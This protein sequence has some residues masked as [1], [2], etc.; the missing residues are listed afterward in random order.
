MTRDASLMSRSF[1]VLVAV[2]M[3]G[4]MIHYSILPGCLTQSFFSVL[5]FSLMET[6]V[7]V[8]TAFH[9][10]SAKF[11]SNIIHLLA[12]KNVIIAAVAFAIAITLTNTGVAF[13]S[14]SGTRLIKSLEPVLVTCVQFLVHARHP[15]TKGS[16]EPA[17]MFLLIAAIVVM[18][19]V[20]PVRMTV[21]AS[22]AAFLSTLGI[23]LRNVFIKK[24]LESGS[25]PSAMSDIQAAVNALACTLF[26]LVVC[27]RVLFANAGIHAD[28]LDLISRLPVIALACVTFAAFQIAA[29]LVL[30]RVS[31]ARQS[32]IKSVHSS[33]VT[34][35]T[36]LVQRPHAGLRLEEIAPTTVW[37][38]AVLAMAADARVDRASGHQP[39]SGALG[40]SSKSSVLVAHNRQLRAWQFLLGVCW[41]VLLCPTAMRALGVYSNN[42][43]IRDEPQSPATL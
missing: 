18:L 20:S 5:V 24:E 23:V 32:A 36:L 12:E 3:A 29:V 9:S 27:A 10:R 1:A 41:A 16:Q 33:V 4:S 14:V 37:C 34:L 31:A 21:Y 38:V 30:G 39:E 13:G 19:G 35:W 8:A 28:V 2:W 6:I 11:P 26:L 42:H 25:L 40:T 15:S 7:T 17:W 22:G 43:A